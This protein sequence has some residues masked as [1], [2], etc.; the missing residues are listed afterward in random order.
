MWYKEDYR[1]IF[2]DMH[3]DD[4]QP[5][6]YLSKLDIDHFVGT[7]KEANVNNVVV[8]AKSHVGLHYWPSKYGRMH[9]GLK[10]RGLDYVGE[11]IKKCKENDISVVVYFSQIYDNYAYEQHPAWRI[12]N[13]EGTTSRENNTR[14]GLVCPNNLEYRAYV[15][16][17]LQELV[18]TYDFGG[19]FL[20]MPFWPGTCYCPACRERY[21]KETGTYIPH[22][23]DWNNPQ[24]V[25]FANRRQ[26]W[27]EEFVAESTRAIKEIKSA[28]SV[29]HNFAAVGCGWINGDTENL[30]ES[31]DYAGGDYYGG[32]LEQTFMCKY[33]NNVTPN[34]PFVYI[35]SRCDPN[36]YAHTVSRCEE[37]L[38]IHAMNALV[39]NG[40]FSVCD[41]MN[42]N[43]TINTEVYHDAIGPV[44]RN[45]CDYEQYVSGDMIAD[46]SI[47]Y[48]TNL[49]AND[50]FIQSPFAI[51]RVL[52]EYNMLY[53]VVG[54]KNL[55]DIKTEVLA[56]NG[57]YSITDEEMDAIEAYV[58]RGGKVFITGKLGH[59]HFEELL[60][61]K[62]LKGS[63]YGYTY[64]NPTE[65]GKGLFE[66]FNASSPYPIERRAIECTLKEEATI[67]ATLTYPYTKA[68][69]KEFSAIH[70]NPPGIHTDMPAVMEKQ[71]GEGKI[72]WV[73]TPLELAYAHYCKKA[74]FSLINS[75]VENKKIESNAP[76]FVELTHWHKEDKDY[77]GIIN[78]QTVSPVYPIDAITITLPFVCKDVK[79]K[80]PSEQPIQVEYE[81][82]KTIICLPK[83]HMFHLVEISY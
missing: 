29:E 78:Q 36:L 44:F 57:A 66:S 31:C 59:K 20:D 69:D 63:E 9:E 12:V 42:P 32:Y 34:K 5:E 18:A 68:G 45:S 27:L 55:K 13:S 43:G 17:I 39:H 81:D 23:E 75:L 67:L 2:M 71:V 61:I 82:G 52:Q 47:W 76:A 3:L 7:L 60:G 24:W 19:M 79:L 72:L 62:E 35:T 25:D 8:K 56:I 4:S 51:A 33:Y 48:N 14:Y 21:W 1:R 6:E 38:Y 77:V 26:R 64:L 70:S 30:L 41:A 80:T 83:L 58:R 11:M 49:K 73:V 46:V 40:A 16:E 10:R 50:N 53:D 15:R 65:A 74:V 37:D 28:V 54:S 22:R